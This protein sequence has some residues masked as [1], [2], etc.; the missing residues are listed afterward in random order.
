[1]INVGQTNSSALDQVADVIE[2]TPEIFGKIKAFFGKK[3]NADAS[4]DEETDDDNKDDESM[5]I[6]IKK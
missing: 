3:K 6:H 5:E 1:M 2:R 4:S